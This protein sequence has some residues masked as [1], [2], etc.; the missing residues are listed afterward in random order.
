MIDIDHNNRIQ[1]KLKDIYETTLDR[2]PKYDGSLTEMNYYN[3]VVKA[4]S[5]DL[6]FN[7]TNNNVCMF[8]YKHENEDSILMLFSIPTTGGDKDKHISERIMD[9]I[10]HTEECFVT[11]DYVNSKEVKDDKFTYIIMIKKLDKIDILLREDV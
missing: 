10:R 9:I 2:G 3:L 5:N 6:L 7:I 1:K 11:L 8:N 4:A